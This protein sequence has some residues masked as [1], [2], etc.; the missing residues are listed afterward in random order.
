MTVRIPAALR[1]VTHGEAVVSEA[2]PSMQVLLDRLEER[3]PGFRD[4]LCQPDG[5]LKRFINIFVNGQE[6]RRL[7]GLET[8]LHDAD[9][10][11]IIPAMAGGSL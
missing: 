6:I 7:Q 9:E 2:A 1:S 10:V 3:Y 8:P 5:D 11:V 4:R